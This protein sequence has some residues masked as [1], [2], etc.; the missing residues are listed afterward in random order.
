MARHSHTR[1]TGRGPSRFARG[2]K[3]KGPTSKPAGISFNKGKG[4]GKKPGPDAPAR[5]GAHPSKLAERIAEIA[6]D[7]LKAVFRQG[8]RASSI[9]DGYP[10]PRRGFDPIDRRLIARSLTALF[11]WWGWIEPLGLSSVKE[12]LLLAWMLD[13][14]QVHPICRIWAN[15][16]GKNPD[17]LIVAGDAPNWT[18]R[19]EGL[20][21]WSGERTVNADPW[22]LFPEWLREQLPNPPGDAS[23]KTRR[24]EFLHTLQAR[25]PLW[26]VASAESEKEVWGMVREK[27]LKPWIHRH[28]TRIAKLPAE[29]DLPS[30]DCFRDGKLWI[31]DLSS[32]ALGIVCDPDPGE[33]WWDVCAG[34]GLRSLNLA[35]QMQGRGFIAATVEWEHQR[36]EIAKRMRQTSYR[37]VAAKIWDGR[38]LPSKPDSFDGVLVDAPS[39]AIGSW[40]RIPDARWIGGASQIAGFAEQQSRLLDLAA[41]GVKTGGSLVYSVSTVTRQE[42][43]DVIQNFLTNHPEFRLAPFPH[44]LDDTATDGMLQLWPQIHDCDARFIARLVRIGQPNSSP[45]PAD[46]GSQKTSARSPKDATSGAATTDTTPADQTRQAEIEVPPH[47]LASGDEANPSAPDSVES[48]S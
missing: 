27:E 45:K 41:Q 12:Q 5:L 42:T 30:L 7:L 29:T 9:I 4:K 24:L 25:P 15:Q 10:D 46:S 37:N 22:R 36:K 31:E 26:V 3:P 20:K 16:V 32:L 28:I 8:K 43:I 40:R 48:S 21:R 1:N 13:S 35:S 39:S 38:K 44:P 11:R 34:S 6:P 17:D 19:A 14:D 23:A 18:M 47:S 2:T 33:R